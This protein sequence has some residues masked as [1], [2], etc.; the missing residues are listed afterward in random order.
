MRREL[1]SASHLVLAAIALLLGAGLGRFTLQGELTRARIALSA[2]EAQPCEDRGTAVGRQI[3]R[4]LSG[5]PVVESRE[6]APRVQRP[7]EAPEPS[8]EPSAIVTGDDP[9]DFDLEDLENMSDEQ[10]EQS[11]E[12]ISDAMALRR[13]QARRALIEQV[14]PSDEQLFEIEDAMT[15][16]NDLLAEEAALFV[17]TVRDH[18]PTQ[19]DGLE[20]ARN[21]I[22]VLLDADDAMRATLTDEQLQQADP[23]VVSPFSFLDERIVESMVEVRQ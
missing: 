19:R 11:F 9:E 7:R 15:T 22:D 8:S 16:M 13:A 1:F 3:A 6:P 21:T 2:A 10:R 23:E 18:E 5:G 14:E 4:A 12:A 20:F 17:D